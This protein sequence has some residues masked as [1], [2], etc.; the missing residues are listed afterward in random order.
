M[1]RLDSSLLS[2]VFKTESFTARYPTSTQM[3]MTAILDIK[4]RDKSIIKSSLHKLD[5]VY[6]TLRFPKRYRIHA[7][8]TKVFPFQPEILGIIFPVF[9]Y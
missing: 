5:P 6:N 7:S 8:I 4:A 1:V 3:S 9:H 2:S